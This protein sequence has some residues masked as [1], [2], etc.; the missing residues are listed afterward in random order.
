[1][2]NEGEPLAETGDTFVDITPELICKMLGH[3]SEQ[4]HVPADARVTG[5]HPRAEHGA[6][7]IYYEIDRGE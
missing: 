4:K 6:I 5:V 3:L 1:M 2:R 7:R